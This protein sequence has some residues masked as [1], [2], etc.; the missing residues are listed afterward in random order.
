VG[1]TFFSWIAVRIGIADLPFGVSWLQLFST[2][3]LAGIGFT[4]SLFIASSAFDQPAL[5]ALA[6]MDILVASVIAA[7]IGFVL[8]TVTSPSPE[9]A[10]KLATEGTAA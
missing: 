9:G 7:A 6:K 5:L 10:S 8:I 3:W 2:S 4:M 1:I